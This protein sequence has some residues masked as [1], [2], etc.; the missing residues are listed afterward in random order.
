MSN[1]REC[2]VFNS[3]IKE[4]PHT[5]QSEWRVYIYTY[6]LSPQAKKPTNSITILYNYN[7]F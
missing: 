6:V 7:I 3:A 4:A 1:Q 2:S 5:K